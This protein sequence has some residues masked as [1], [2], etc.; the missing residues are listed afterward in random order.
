MPAPTGATPEA[1]AAA[2]ERGLATLPV[3]Q[4][5][6]ELSML[7]TMGQAFTPDVCRQLVAAEVGPH[8]A[9]GTIPFTDVHAVVFQRYAVVHLVP[10]GP[11]IDRVLGAHGIAAQK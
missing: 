9:G 4:L 2:L 10:V 8:L 5:T 3:D 7:R 11:V 6:A 1:F